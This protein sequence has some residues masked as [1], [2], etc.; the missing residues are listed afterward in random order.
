MNAHVDA[1]PG[2][3]Y[4]VYYLGVASIIIVYVNM[5]YFN[6][7]SEFYNIIHCY[8]FSVL[9]IEVMLANHLEC[10]KLASVCPPFIKY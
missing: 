5:C 4:E 6:V 2:V 1:I 10:D 7:F 8:I 3:I 9:E